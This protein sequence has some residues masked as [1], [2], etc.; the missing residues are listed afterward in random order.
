MIFATA[1]TGVHSPRIPP[2]L[3]C[4][5]DRKA[6]PLFP[7]VSKTESAGNVSLSFPAQF[8]PTHC[9]LADSLRSLLI[10]LEEHAGATLAACYRWFHE[11]GV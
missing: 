2:T 10:R 6:P 7:T 1:L 4:G 3:L 9:M 11:K 5:A 8:N